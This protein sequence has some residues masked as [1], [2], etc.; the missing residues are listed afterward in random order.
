MRIPEALEFVAPSETE[1]RNVYVEFISFI[2]LHIKLS[3][4]AT[5]CKKNIYLCKWIRLY[6]FATNFLS[7]ILEAVSFCKLIEIRNIS[8]SSSVYNVRLRELEKPSKTENCESTGLRILTVFPPEF[9]FLSP[10]VQPN[11]MK[12]NENVGVGCPS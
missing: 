8:K 10:T 5:V 4:T 6:S 9:H 11:V 12:Q 3:C 2:D 7:L 1:R